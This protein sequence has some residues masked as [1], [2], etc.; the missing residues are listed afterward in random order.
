[1]MEVDSEAMEEDP[2]EDVV[3]RTR[4]RA[5]VIKRVFETVNYLA[6]HRWVSQG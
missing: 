4:T 5:M 3:V 2:A 6:R 1:M